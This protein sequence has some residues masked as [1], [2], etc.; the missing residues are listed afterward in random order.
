AGQRKLDDDT[1]VLMVPP[2]CEVHF[3][4]T[5]G[6]TS[7]SGRF[8]VH[9]SAYEVAG[10]GGLRFT[11]E[12][13]QIARPELV[14]FERVLVPKNVEADRGS[15]TFS[16]DLPQPGEGALVLR[17]SFAGRDDDKRAFGFWTEVEIHR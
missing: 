2:E 4:V 10:N 15:Q 3:T 1:P 17:T 5:R 6:A 9:P 14:V 8:G 7:V 13:R 11:I 16:V 12:Y